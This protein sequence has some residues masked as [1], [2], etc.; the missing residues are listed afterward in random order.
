MRVRE[1]FPQVIKLAILAVVGGFLAW[2][3]VVVNMADQF[4]QSEDP[5]DAAAAIK[6]DSTHSGALYVHANSILEKDPIQAKV[7]L[8]ASIRQDPANAPAYIALA[9]LLEKQAHLVEAKRAV[10]T[11]VRMA[12]ERVDV[13]SDA[14]AFWIR[15]NDLGKAIENWNV[16]LT[17]APEIGRKLFPALTAVA[18]D[19]AAQKAFATLLKQPVS[20]W[21]DFFAHVAANAPRLDTVRAL[22]N[23][24]AKGPND[25]TQDALR[26]YL[27]RLQHDG[28][29]T[30]SYFVWLNSLDEVQ[31]KNV[32]NL[33][34]GGFEAPLTNLGFD[35][36]SK[37][38]GYVLVET[39][40]TYGDSGT[41]ALHVLFRGPRV[42]FKHLGQYLM[43]APGAYT[44]Y[45]RVRVDD[46][47]VQGNE[48]GAHWVLYCLGTAD[49][50]AASDRFAGTDQWRRFNVQ[51]TVPEQGCPIQMLRLELAGR[52]ALDFQV[53]GGV[54]F[55]DM[56]ID[57]QDLD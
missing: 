12:P 5:D 24:Q 50:V 20:W 49:P 35:W 29:W 4:A 23:L 26:A 45:G 43:L 37:E 56:G 51:F 19:P 30:E 1:T 3:I 7:E 6:W 27:E 36:I 39:G 53:K 55:D 52:A 44:L 46:L 48:G 41:K 54:W 17:F 31:I 8:E 2:R 34:N 15:Q 57:R 42:A 47:E 14:A 13:R 38:A 11:A 16:V 21:P 10:D 32:G 33:F 25:A 28:Y 18:D 40:P 22:Y 9:T